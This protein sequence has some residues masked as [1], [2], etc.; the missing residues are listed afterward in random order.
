MVEQICKYIV[1]QHVPDV[2]VD[3]I[4]HEFLIHHDLDEVVD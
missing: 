2:E 1:E 4:L 3:L